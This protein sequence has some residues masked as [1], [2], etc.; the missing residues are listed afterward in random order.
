V[1][2]RFDGNY[3]FQV[4]GRVHVDGA[5]FT[6]LDETN[7]WKGILFFDAVP[8]SYFK[9]TIIEGACQ[10]GVRIT[11]T[12][13]VFTNCTIRNNS[14]PTHGGG[15]LAKVSSA[16]LVIVQCTISNNIANPNNV[17]GDFYGGG[18]YVEGA[19]VLAQSTV[20]SNWIRGTRAWGGGVFA[21]D[22]DCTMRN[23]LIAYNFPNATSR[24]NADGVYFDGQTS[25][26]TLNMANCTL[27]GN[28]IPGTASD[29]GGGGLLSYGKAILVNCIAT[30]NAREG[31]RFG[32]GPGEGSVV[33]CTVVGNAPAYFGIYS[34]GPAVGVTNSILY[35]NHAGGDQFG[36]NVSF[37]Y[38]DVQGGAPPGPGNISF[39][40]G[41]CPNQSLIQGSPC[42]DAG[43]PDPVFN[44]G[45]IDNEGTCTPYSRG[46]ARN[47]MGAFG[48]PSACCWANL[49]GPVVIPYPPQNVTTCIEG[50][51]NFCVAAIG[52]QPLQYQWRFHG[53][54]LTTA[55]TNVVGGTNA[56]LLLSNVQ[57][58]DAGYYS[59]VV[60]NAVSTAVSPAAL[61]SVTP[62]CTE[63]NLYAGLTITGGR[64]G[65]EYRVQYVSNVND[66]PWADLTT[67]TQNTGGVFVLD[68]TPANLQRRFYRV[69]P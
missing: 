10:S 34:D 38:S 35:F 52:D 4:G 36:G 55:G 68:P 37:A 49:C 43:S 6:P 7:C 33:N 57:S 28:G 54:N 51:A 5:R 3:E 60:A 41:L 17:G 32:V 46:A 18:I 31:F 47:D 13:P 14:S 56:C 69:V 42:I 16:P 62:V 11:N 25:G 45:C 40:P 67:V 1:T 27:S 30:A 24:D 8:G 2:V 39:A 22:G 19:M 20:V 61:L 12:P 58:N 48:G 65:Q 64:T 50:N 63:I 59:V 15:I 29:Y 53:T 66:T 26:G 44:D 9:D 23:C 21:R